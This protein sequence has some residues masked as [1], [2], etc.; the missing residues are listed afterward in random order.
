MATEL[1]EGQREAIQAARDMFAELPAQ[2]SPELAASWWAAIR[3][4]FQK[5]R[6]EFACEYPEQ[7]PPDAGDSA[8][9]PPGSAS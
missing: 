2:P 6:F 7:P 3:G 5:I 4:T 9:D 1:T 8:D